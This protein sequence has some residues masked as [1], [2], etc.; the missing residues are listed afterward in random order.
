M[1]VGKSSFALIISVY[2]GVIAIPSYPP[3]EVYEIIR[4]LKETALSIKE[5]QKRQEIKQ[6]IKDLETHIK[7][8][9]SLAEEFTREVEK[10]GGIERW[11]TENTLRILGLE[12]EFL[13]KLKRVVELLPE[14][15]NINDIIEEMGREIEDEDL[16]KLINV[17]RYSYSKGLYKYLLQN[18][19]ELSADMRF[20]IINLNPI[21]DFLAFVIMLSKKGEIVLYNEEK[22]R[23]IF[24]KYLN[25]LL[26]FWEDIE[27]IKD[28]EENE[29]GELVSIH[30]IMSI[31]KDEGRV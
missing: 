30:E 1:L 19:E 25:D 20:K 6:A 22:V 13:P 17:L 21:V 9:I 7:K 28:M 5:Y 8:F 11:I 27:L 23:K 26:E 15:R 18:I 12:L 10:G 2:M 24:R 14:I 29:T 16:D 31:F 4:V 3:Y